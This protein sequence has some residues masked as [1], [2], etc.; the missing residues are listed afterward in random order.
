MNKCDHEGKKASVLLATYNGEKYIREQLESLAEQT[1]TDFICYIH[2]DGSRDQTLSICREYCQHD[3]ERFKILEY[4]KAGGAKENFLSLLDYADGDYVF[5]CD[6]DD[7]WLPEKM[8]KMIRAAE[9]ADGECLVYCDLKVTNES[10]QVISDSYYSYIRFYPEQM[11]QHNVLI[12]SGIPGCAIMATRGIVQLAMKYR[13]AEHL[14]MHDWWVCLAAMMSGAQAIGICEPLVMYRQHGDNSVGAAHY[15]TI[16]KIRNASRRLF[17][18]TLRE[19]KKHDM[20]L[21]RNQ[22][23]ELYDSGIGTDESR[24]F[25]KEYIELSGKNKIERIRFY[26]QYFGKM[27]RLGWLLLWA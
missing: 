11:D 26:L 19:T 25:L 24:Q 17:N 8:E 7:V 23:K 20:E 15:S 12:R 3:P 22:A 9:Q 6:Q 1:W 27:D 16:D 21:I 18:G 5:F 14:V 4:E 10:L 13:N 2:D